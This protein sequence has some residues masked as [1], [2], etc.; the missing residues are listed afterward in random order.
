MSTVESVSIVFDFWKYIMDILFVLQLVSQFNYAWQQKENKQNSWKR[1][2]FISSF[3]WIWKFLKF[4]LLYCFLLQFNF[5]HLA[6]EI[7]RCPKS[8]PLAE[9]NQLHFFTTKHTSR[10]HALEISRRMGSPSI[11]DCYF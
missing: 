4:K 2:P 6:S 9:F 11:N 3:L 7:F 8:K 1:R 10:I 5:S